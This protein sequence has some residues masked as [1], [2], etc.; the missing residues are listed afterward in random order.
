MMRIFA[1]AL[2]IALLVAGGAYLLIRSGQTNNPS[3]T[4]TT[5]GN[6]FGGTL[7]GSG[8]SGGTNGYTLTVHTTDGT[9]IQIPDFTNGHP[10]MTQPSGTY[11]YVTEDQ[12][13]NYQYT[14]FNIVYGNDSTFAIGLL[15]EP[16]GA[17]RLHAE[18]K[19]RTLTGLSGDQLCKLNVTVM[20]SP[21]VN[22][23]YAGV[24]L[25]LSFCPGATA[26]P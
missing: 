3:G 23:T 25:G 14:D 26:L 16:L 5:S 17:A 1:V 2:L 15:A 24:N 11:Y 21:R 8:A 7:S 18:D 9:T 13:Q 20:A 19:L 10:S 22:D 4:N 12:D 6:P